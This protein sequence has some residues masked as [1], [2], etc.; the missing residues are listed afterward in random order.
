MD[1]GIINEMRPRLPEAEWRLL[2]FGLDQV[3]RD[4]R[5]GL[6]WWMLLLAV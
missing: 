6:E 1:P 2:G 5:A 4:D 3:A